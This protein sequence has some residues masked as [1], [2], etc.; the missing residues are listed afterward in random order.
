[1]LA[2]EE[3]RRR[4]KEEAAAAANT[5]SSDNNGGGAPPTPHAEKRMLVKRES[6]AAGG[7]GGG[8]S[9]TASALEA[10]G[11]DTTL[12]LLVGAGGV[13]SD[14]NDTSLIGGAAAENEG[15]EEEDAKRTKPSSRSPSKNAKKDGDS[16][17]GAAD[18]TN[19]AVKTP[20]PP[21]PRVTPPVSALSNP[22]SF[23]LQWEQPLVDII[24]AKAKGLFK[25]GAEDGGGGG[26]LS[27]SPVDGTS[28]E[29]GT[30]TDPLDLTGGLELGEKDNVVEEP[31]LTEPNSRA[32]AHSLASSFGVYTAAC[33]LSKRWRLREAA[34]ATIAAHLVANVGGT[35]SSTTPFLFGGST[36]NGNANTS[37]SDADLAT[38]DDGCSYSAHTRAAIYALIMYADVKGFGLSD[39]VSSVASQMC[40]LLQGVLCGRFKASGSTSRSTSA[41]AVTASNA[42]GRDGNDKEAATNN[43]STERPPLFCNGAMINLLPR[44]MSRAAAPSP[45]TPLNAFTRGTELDL[46][47]SG[48]SASPSSLLTALPKDLFI[49]PETLL[50]DTG[51]AASALPALPILA[52]QTIVGGYVP[53][54]GIDRVLQYGICADPMDADKRKLSNVSNKIQLN[55][56]GLLSMLM[57]VGMNAMGGGGGSGSLSSSSSSSTSAYVAMA[58]QLLSGAGGTSSSA[59]SVSIAIC[60]T[61]IAPSSPAEQLLMT[62]LLIPTLSHPHNGVREAAISCT[63]KM[64]LFQGRAK[65]SAASAA[66]ATSDDANNTAALQVPVIQPLLTALVKKFGPKIGNSAKTAIEEQCAK[67]QQAQQLQQ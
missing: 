3:R 43:N 5:S 51:H 6:R 61:F 42:E 12:P 19:T 36:A 24:H 31:L 47:F 50:N 30:I 38:G 7:G 49:T 37:S 57:G 17:E 14:A 58:Q 55:R 4:E 67:Q 41:P 35:S 2:E 8:H 59:S 46:L 48:S 34:L 40:L 28:A 63:V 16:G 39:A 1:M 20:S 65:N 54:I 66:A 53:Y 62:K 27:A 44:L 56:L 33:L 52:L 64:L 13:G 15:N 26:G 45:M 21:P 32:E 22:T 23:Y 9:S 10:S 11:G 60:S 18:D 25:G 29:D